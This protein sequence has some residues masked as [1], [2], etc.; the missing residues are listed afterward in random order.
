MM[1]CDR[2]GNKSP[3]SFCGLHDEVGSVPVHPSDLG[4]VLLMAVQGAHHDTNGM[5][6]GLIAGIVKQHLVTMSHADKLEL[7]ERLERLIEEARGPKKTTWSVL[8]R[9]VKSP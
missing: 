1:N 4:T 3:C 9:Q 7:R 6:A 8:L 2:C 5:Y